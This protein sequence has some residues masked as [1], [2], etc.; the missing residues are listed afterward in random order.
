PRGRGDRMRRREFIAGLGAAA[1]LPAVWPLATRAQ[2]DGRVRQV[3]M[4]LRGD[5]TDRILEGDWLAKLG[6]IEGRNVRFDRRFSADDADRLRALADELVRLAPDVIVVVSLPATRLVLQRTRTIPI[7]FSNVGDPVAGGLLQDIARPEGNVTGITSVYQ[8]M[9]GKWLQLLKEAAPQIARV[10]LIFNS[11]LVSE[12][13]FSSIDA[14]AEALAVKA[15]RAPYRNVA[16]LERII[17]TFGAEPNGGLIMVP[18]PPS[19]STRELI[20]RLAVKY[21]LPTIYPGKEYAAAGGMMG[22]G[23]NNDELL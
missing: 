18:P 20:N 11:D 16:E 17:D 14:A 8:S 10:A 2:Q 15:I 1:I 6:W 7:V 13:Y 22:Y 4:L 3:G 21:R 5:P 9:G 12:T 19:G 23:T